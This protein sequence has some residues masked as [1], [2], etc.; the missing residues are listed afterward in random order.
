MRPANSLS[1]NFIGHLN[2]LEMTRSKMEYLFSRNQIVRRDIEQIYTGLYMEV[3]TSLETLIEKLFIGLLVGNLI[4]RSSNVIPRVTFRSSL[5]AR[6]IVYGG[7]RYADWL[8]YDRT[9][10]RANAFFRRGVPFT[11]LDNTEKNNIDNILCIRNAIAHK[12]NYSLEKFRE[13]II[14]QSI[15]MPRERTPAGYLRSKFRIAPVQTRYEL[16]VSNISS[17]AIR[18]CG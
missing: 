15:L 14:G 16:L 10:K 7:R 9:E 18:L 4:H 3:V 2:Y 17:I 6:E 1:T 11:L 13:K 12:S 8:P 5:V